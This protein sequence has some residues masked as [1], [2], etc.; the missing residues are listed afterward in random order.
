MVQQ[1]EPESTF[2]K[3]PTGR[4]LSALGASGYFVEPQAPGWD[5][6]WDSLCALGT[7]QVRARHHFK[8]PQQGSRNERTKLKP[9]TQDM[10]F[11]KVGPRVQGS[12]PELRSGA[13]VWGRAA[14]RG[15]PY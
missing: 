1:W 5:E 7:G 14:V 3:G 4:S 9:N 11:L 12:R 6:G 13:E 8:Y 10:G 15:S 2:L